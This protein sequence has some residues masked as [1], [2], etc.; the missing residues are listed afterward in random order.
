MIRVT[1]PECHKPIDVPQSQAGKVETCAHCGGEMTIP[2]QGPADNAPTSASGANAADKNPGG[3]SVWA[4]L[5]PTQRLV[6]G[7]T[8]G[9]VAVMCFVPPCRCRGL[10]RY[11]LIFA[12][13]RYN[14]D[15]YRLMAQ[16]VGTVVIATGLF[17]WAGARPGPL[18]FWRKR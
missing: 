5:T 13:G 3:N 9:L 2:A 15:L 12:M 11:R 17:L 16:I 4:R 8:V 10:S 1:C 7:V 6:V 18:P 14:I